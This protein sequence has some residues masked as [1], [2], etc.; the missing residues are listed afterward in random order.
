M[1]HQAVTKMLELGVNED[2]VRSVAGHVSQDILRRYSH[3]RYA[4][5]RVAV[6]ALSGVIARPKR[7]GSRYATKV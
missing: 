7:P 4:A 5:K 2:A 3:Q 1:R 6:D